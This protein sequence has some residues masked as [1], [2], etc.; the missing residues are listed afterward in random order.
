MDDIYICDVTGVNNND[1][2]GDVKIACIFPDGAGAHADFTPDSGVNFARVNE[3]V[4]D[5]DTSYVE[6]AA[7]GNQDSYSFDDIVDTDVAIVGIQQVYYSKK[8]DSGGAL[9]KSLHR[10]S[11]VDALSTQEDSI[12]TDY[13]YQLFPLDTDPCD[14]ND[15]SVT[16]VNSIEAG[17][18]RTG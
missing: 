5:G 15:W 2:L 1:F 16:K 12:P 13:G 18:E 9:F 6:G 4:P 14:G 17:M 7:I 10:R 11:G 3:V 8:M